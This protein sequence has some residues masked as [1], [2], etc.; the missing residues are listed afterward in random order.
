[1]KLQFTFKIIISK[2]I[3]NK[4]NYENRSYGDITKEHFAV[5]PK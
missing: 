1:M 5:D 2:N 3:L 4:F